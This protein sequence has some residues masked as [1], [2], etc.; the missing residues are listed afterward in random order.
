MSGYRAASSYKINHRHG[1]HA[2]TLES[3]MREVRHTLGDIDFQHEAELERL[4]ASGVDLH[5]RRRIEERLYA[6]HRARREPYVEVLAGLR[7][8]QHR[9]AFAA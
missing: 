4:K 7:R 9:Q 8:G 3:M 2:P 5:S 1:L 6:R